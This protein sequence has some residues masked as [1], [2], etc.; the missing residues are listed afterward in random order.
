[1]GG[2]SVL[3]AGLRPLVAALMGGVAA[4]ALAQVQPSPPPP[5]PD[6]TTHVE[7]RTPRGDSSVPETPPA[8]LPEKKEKVTH[9]VAE[10]PLT[11]LATDNLS[12]LYFDPV[13]TYLTPYIARAFENALQADE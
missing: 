10:I 11:E 2:R 4:P 13:Q 9:E 3:A 5:Q 12:L 6:T 8:P 7:Q 1:M